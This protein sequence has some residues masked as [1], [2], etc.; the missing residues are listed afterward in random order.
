MPKNSKN[1]GTR[2]NRR[3]STPNVFV[4]SAVP[5]NNDDDQ[6]ET[7][8]VAESSSSHTG[9]RVERTNRRASVRSE[10]Y[11]RSLSGELRKM[12]ALSAGIVVVLV[13]LTFAL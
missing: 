11:T 8:T 7:S 5:D 2:K 13:V 4:Q 9:I 10:I 12:G 3:S 6:G 1:T